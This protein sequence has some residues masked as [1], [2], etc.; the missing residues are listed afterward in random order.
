MDGGNQ[1]PTNLLP[2]F[3]KPKQS[4]TNLVYK[5]S[6]AVA[7]GVLTQAP[8]ITQFFLSPS[9]LSALPVPCEFATVS[10]DFEIHEHCYCS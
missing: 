8:R 1:S 9:S 7:A 4:Q 6:S 5:A 2:L 3:N 10:L